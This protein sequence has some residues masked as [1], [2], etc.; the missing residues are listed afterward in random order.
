MMPLFEMRAMSDQLFLYAHPDIPDLTAGA[1]RIAT[2]WNSCLSALPGGQVRLQTCDGSDSQ[3]WIYNRQKGTI[4]HQPFYKC[5]HVPGSDPQSGTLVQSLLCRSG[6]NQQWTYD[7]ETKLLRSA[8]GTA[9]STGGQF[10]L[11]VV[12]SYGGRQWVTNPES[13]DTDGDG[14]TDHLEEV[15]GTNPLNP[16]TD[17]DG[18]GDASDNCPLKENPGNPQLDT[19]GDGVGD[20]CDPCRDD[21]DSDGDG[22]GDACDDYD[23]AGDDDGDGVA[24][25][26]D[27]CP[28]VFNDQTDSDG[29]F[30]GDAC[31]TTPEP[32]RDGDGSPDSS[33]S[34]PDVANTHMDSDY[35]GIDDACDAT[36]YPDSDS[37]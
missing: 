21:I 20:A 27:N 2:G 12:T 17:G 35:D 11:E 8:L 24:N 37:Q 28:D 36:P 1:P 19:D 18:E 7:P 14:L 26:H 15:Y 32:D 6:D 34:C 22:I 30:I 13:W 3:V 33:D 5:L 4:S 10:G 23:D 31:D 25:G 29:D 9:L 16:D